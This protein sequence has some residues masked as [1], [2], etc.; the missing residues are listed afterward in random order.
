MEVAPLIRAYLFLPLALAVGACAVS[1]TGQ[2]QLKLFPDEQMSQMGAAAFAQ[3]RKDTPETKNAG[4][5]R[6][7]QC[8]AKAVAA[9]ARSG[10]RWEVRVFDSPE[11]NAFALPGGKIGV[12]AG[13]LEVASNQDQLAAIIGHEITHV[14]ANHGNARVSASYATQASLQAAQVL[15]GAPSPA[16]QQL[17]GLLGLGAQYGVLMPY[18]RAQE[19]ESDLLGLDLMANAG[20]DPRQAVE[21]WRNMATLSRGKQPPVFLSTHPS[22]EGRI[23]ALSERMKQAM[24][25]YA[26]AQNR[27]KRPACTR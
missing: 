13:I 26:A 8:V 22:H 7:V 11:A 6:Y 21:L 4:V 19:T 27:G 9:E 24:G 17:L 23:G 5:K 1:P 15:A 3:T 25:L 16:K 18:G 2:R 12:Y 20:F 10:T 14:T